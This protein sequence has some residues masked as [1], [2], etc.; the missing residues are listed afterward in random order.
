MKSQL[1]A[2]FL[3]IYCGIT[4][5]NTRTVYCPES[6][7]CDESNNISSCKVNWG[8]GNTAKW[9]TG[10]LSYGSA[11]Q[12]GT[13]QFEKSQAPYDAIDKASM[14]GYC[15]YGYKVNAKITKYIFIHGNSF[16]ASSFPLDNNNWT[17]ASTANDGV[18][19]NCYSSNPFECPLAMQS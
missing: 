5:A 3:L 17:M 9:E 11:V 19:A 10:E 7:I 14:H 12:S 16:Q 2:L 18:F 13:Y 4:S 1:S 6:I 15:S 8:Q